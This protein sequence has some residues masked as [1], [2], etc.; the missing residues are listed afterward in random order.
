MNPKDFKI[1]II[2][3]GQLGKMLIQE[4]KKMDFTVL[5]L[6]P[7][8][9][10][11]GGKI[12]DHHII[13]DFYDKDKIRELVEQC[14]VT[15]FEI[16][17]IDTEILSILEGEGNTIFP[18]PKLLE[19]IK[20][21]SKQKEMLQQNNIPTSKWKRINSLEETA[22]EL[23][24]PFVQKSCCGGYDGRGVYVVK[25]E[26]GFSEALKGESFGEEF[27]DFEKE[28]GIMVARNS[29]GETK[30]FPVVEMVFDHKEN[31]CDMIIAPGKVDKDIEKKAKDLAIKCIEG[32]DGVGVFGIEMFLTKDGDVLINEI[33]PRVHNSGHYT[34]ESCITSQFEQHI[35][36]I[37]GMPLGS[38]E[39]IIPSVVINI[40][41]Q[42]GQHGNPYYQGLK[43]V[44]EIPGVNT[45]IYG[46][47]YIKPYRK[48]GHVTVVDRD[49]NEAINKSNKVKKVLKAISM[50][51]NSVE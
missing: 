23:G 15:T 44:L 22:E 9:C 18:S 42:E 2:G 12:A 1:G 49:I 26:E 43:E 40:L 35:R 38:T 28:L 5:V 27:V 32:L 6:D 4:A 25:N 10:A 11:P 16:E 39:L 20:D 33:A 50:E 17:N 13:G 45:H 19:T 24:L 14:D 21:K 30:C 31:I 37:C 46:K 48:M 36:A 34:I 8:T 29:R 7:S 3:G 41:G 47:E 51:V